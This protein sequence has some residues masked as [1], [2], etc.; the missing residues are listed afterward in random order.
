MVLVGPHRGVFADVECVGYLA[1][2]H[3]QGAELGYLNG[4]SLV[5]IGLAGREDLDSGANLGGG[6]IGCNRVR[7][8]DQLEPFRLI[9]RAVCC[10]CRQ[11]PTPRGGVQACVPEPVAQPGGV[12]RL[13]DRK[14]GGLS[15]LVLLN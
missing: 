7:H 9:P 13:T 2:G 3:A 8:C 5:G 10:M 1:V 14:T 15:T 11:S 12:R 6:R 4:K